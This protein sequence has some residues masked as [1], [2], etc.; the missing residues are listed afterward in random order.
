MFD[1]IEEK[2]KAFDAITE[3]KDANKAKKRAKRRKLFRD[4]STTP[5]A[6]T[7]LRARDHF[8]IHTFYSI[9]DCLTVEL[10]KWLSAYSGRHK[11]FS[12]VPEL[13]SLTLDDLRK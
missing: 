8:R 9:V 3:Y 7:E 2:A 5:A 4:E 1:D 12:F 6:N 13:E 11:L 10:C